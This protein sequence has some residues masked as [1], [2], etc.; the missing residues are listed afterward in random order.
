MAGLPFEVPAILWRTVFAAQVAV[1]LHPGGVRF[2]F[3]RG[4]VRPL[5]A[6][7]VLVEAAFLTLV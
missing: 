4:P 6:S 7:R 5:V 3:R 1:M 2:A